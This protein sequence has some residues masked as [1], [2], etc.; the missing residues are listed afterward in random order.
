MLPDAARPEIVAA[1]RALLR[2]ELDV[3]AGDLRAGFVLDAVLAL[4]GPLVYERAVRDVQAYVA[5]VVADLDV[6]LPPPRT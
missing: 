6:N 2:D 5:R 4:A 3:D 1:V